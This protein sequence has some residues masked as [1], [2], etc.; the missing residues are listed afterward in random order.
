[1][2]HLELNELDYQQRKQRRLVN[3][4]AFFKNE[5]FQVVTATM[6]NVEEFLS[7]YNGK[8]V[9]YVVTNH[10]H[11]YACHD[12]TPGAEGAAA[13]TTV[14]KIIEGMALMQGDTER[15]SAETI[16][17]LVQTNAIKMFTDPGHGWLRVP[18]SL[19]NYLGI[20]PL[21]TGY[22]YVDDKNAYLEEDCDLS[23]FLCA[24]GLPYTEENKP[25]CRLFWQCCPISESNNQS[26]I[27]RF[28]SYDA[29]QITK[30][31]NGSSLAP[32]KGKVLTLFP[33]D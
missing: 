3:T 20:A 29:E 28:R 13:T 4:V 10:C 11:L 7:S 16:Q 18:L 25:L 17:E 5:Q 6:K 2:L 33:Q 21:I 12:H 15:V 1:M 24:I 14:T 26:S 30:R 9:V 19:I 23:T 31:F 27:R 8:P 22:S 32:L